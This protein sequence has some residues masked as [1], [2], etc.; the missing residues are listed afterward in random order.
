MSVRPF[1]IESLISGRKSLLS[2]GPQSKDGTMTTILYIRNKGDIS[3]ALKIRCY[4]DT[5]DNLRIDVIDSS[6]GKTVY[7][8]T[9][10]Y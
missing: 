5:E 1:W 6:N 10:I 8:V 3:E 9:S 4:T 2:G 7:S